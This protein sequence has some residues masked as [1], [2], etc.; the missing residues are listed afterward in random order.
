[1]SDYS[2]HAADINRWRHAAWWRSA[3]FADVEWGHRTSCDAVCRQQTLK[4][5]YLAFTN[6][7]KQHG[8]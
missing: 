2:L 6:T 5:M 4:D 1:M 7:A 8:L 3:A